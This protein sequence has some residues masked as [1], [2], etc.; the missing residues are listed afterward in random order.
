ME[1][2]PFNTCPFNILCKE[3][4]KHIY[5][6]PVTSCKMMV[7]LRKSMC[8]VEL[9][10]KW[11]IEKWTNCG[12]SDRGVWQ[13][14]FSKMNKGSLSLR[15]KQL[16]IFVANNAMFSS[17]SQNFGKAV[18]V[19]MNLTA[20]QSLKTSQKEIGGVINKGDFVF[21]YCATKCVDIWKI[22]MSQRPSVFQRTSWGYYRIM[23]GVN[24]HSQC[25]RG[26]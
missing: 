14:F 2:Q 24:I 17:K 22:C 6:T 13:T 19:I 3:T 9:P 18:S 1:S 10:F 12:F 7:F 8:G 5:N 26:W 16:T 25:R 11:D 21:E 20:S 4:S 15:G 23:H